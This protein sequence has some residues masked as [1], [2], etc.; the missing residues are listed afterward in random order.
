MITTTLG[1]FRRNK[2][3]LSFHRLPN[4]Q[5]TQYVPCVIHQNVGLHY[6]SNN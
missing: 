1:A 2:K 6:C 4:D 5:Q 3:F